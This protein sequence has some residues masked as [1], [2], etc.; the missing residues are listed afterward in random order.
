VD[1]PED[2][3]ELSE[4]PPLLPMPLSLDPLHPASKPAATNANS[5]FFIMFLLG[6]KVRA[7]VKGRNG[8]PTHFGPNAGPTLS[9]KL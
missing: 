3:P 6:N 7:E 4:L 5:N 2:E 1:R 8:A 9:R